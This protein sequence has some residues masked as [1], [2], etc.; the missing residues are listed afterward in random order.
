MYFASSNGATTIVRIRIPI[1]RST[2]SDR[3]GFGFEWVQAVGELGFLHAV[4]GL[5]KLLLQQEFCF[6]TLP[7]S[8]RHQFEVAIIC[9]KDWNLLSIAAILEPIQRNAGSL[10][11]KQIEV[12]TKNTTGILRAP[13]SQQ[14]LRI[15]P[16]KGGVVRTLCS[17]LHSSSWTVF[18]RCW[19]TC[20]GFDLWA[21]WCG[22]PRSAN[23]RRQREDGVLSED[24][25][26][27]GVILFKFPPTFWRF[28][29][30]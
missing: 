14:R 13:S 23:Q 28:T 11:D 10:F 5:L 29:S 8:A 20:G 27:H 16:E 9:W 2:G 26:A 19:E 30:W 21:E 17:S 6:S 24:A 15:L 12:G 18:R 1:K 25:S 4:N 3:Q 7:E 22:V